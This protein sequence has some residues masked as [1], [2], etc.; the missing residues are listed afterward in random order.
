MHVLVTRPEPDSLKLVGLLEQRG[1]EAIA[2][3]LVSFVPLGLDAEALEGVTGLIA[4]SRNAL[5]ALVGAEAL[6]QARALTVYAV[7]AATAEEARRM[8]FSRIIRGPGT[9]A[10]LAPLIASMID[11]AEEVLLHLAGERLAFDLARELGMT[12]IRV[13]PATVY[14]MEAAASLPP[15][16]VAAIAGAD[17]DAVLL[18][19]PDTAAVWVRLVAR[20]GLGERARELAHLCLSPAVATRLARLSPATIEVAARPTLEEML[21]LVDLAAAQSGQ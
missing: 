12:G 19:S 10:G 17:L 2:A 13:T 1:H 7:G 6:E 16:V 20:H 18:M 3:P 15:E 14:R 21:A 9:A 5:R 8:G 4:T 11:P